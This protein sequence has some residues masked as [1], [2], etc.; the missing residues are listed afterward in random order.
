M[1]KNNI[2]PS[3]FYFLPCWVHWLEVLFLFPTFLHFQFGRSRV[4]YP[5]HIQGVLELRHIHSWSIRTKEG[6]SRHIHGVLTLKGEGSGVLNHWHIHWVLELRREGDSWIFMEYYTKE[7]RSKHIHG[8]LELRGC[9]SRMLI[10]SYQDVLELRRG[11]PGI[12]M[13]Y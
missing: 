1:K 2:N 6:R 9:R 8:V 12:F 5:K 4:V 13:E 7:G 3:Y 11:D 10:S